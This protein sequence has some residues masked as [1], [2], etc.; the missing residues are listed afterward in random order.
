MKETKQK[1]IIEADINEAEDISVQEKLNASKIQYPVWKGKEIGQTITGYVK[2]ILTFKDLNGKDKHGVL[3]NLQTKNEKF[4]V[5]SVWANTVILSGLKR[6][7]DQKNFN[8][9]ETMTE[10]L[11]TVESKVIALRFEGMEEPSQKGFKPYQNY[12][13][14]EI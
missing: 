1:E 2:E 4:P 11:K 9:F 7:A 13:V 8:N 6:I 5:V 10:S 3:V 12:T 14:T